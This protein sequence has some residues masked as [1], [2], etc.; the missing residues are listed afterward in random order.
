MHHTTWNF[1][2]VSS[3]TYPHLGTFFE[4][5]FLAVENFIKPQRSTN[6]KVFLTKEN[7]IIKFLFR[8]PFAL[9]AEWITR[10]P[11]DLKVPVSIPGKTRNEWKNGKIS[12]IPPWTYFQFMIVKNIIK[13][14]CISPWFQLWSTNFN[15][16]TN[17]K[18]G[19]WCINSWS[20]NSEF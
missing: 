19:V 20:I 17:K 16:F 1:A 2:G 5:T 7:C 15:F 18:R 11:L 6:R 9:M 12:K 10:W 4:L 3:P 8:A 14:A 13:I